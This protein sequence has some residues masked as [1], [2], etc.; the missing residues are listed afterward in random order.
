MIKLVF[1][2]PWDTFTTYTSVP[3][4]LKDLKDKGIEAQGLDL[5]LQI[6]KRLL[7]K[8]RLE[9]AYEHFMQLDISL[10]PPENVSTYNHIKRNADFIIDNIEATKDRLLQKDYHLHSTPRIDWEIISIATQLISFRFYPC[11]WYRNSYWIHGLKKKRPQTFTEMFSH[12]D[13]AESDFFGWA[14]E[15]EE[16]LPLLISDSVLVGISICTLS[17]LLPSMILCKT[18]KKYNKNTHIVLGGA[19][20]RYIRDPIMQ[21]P[22]VFDYADFIVFGRGEDT[23][24]HLYKQLATVGH[25]QDI[26]GVTYCGNNCVISNKEADKLLYN[27]FAP[28]DYTAMNIHEYLCDELEISYSSSYGCYWGKCAFCSETNVNNDFP[29]LV[30]SADIVCQELMQIYNET[31]IEVIEM[32]DNAI[33]VQKALKIAEFV[34]KNK[35]PLK[36]TMLARAEKNFG[37]DELEYLYKGGLRFVSWGIE[38]FNP[39]MQDY[40]H[41]GIDLEYA[42]EILKYSHEI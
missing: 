11:L 28:P 29:Y 32:M 39:R 5:N 36:W 13:R 26:P 9:E 22:E 33:P 18:L 17:Q 4:L 6:I 41:K 35:L 2:P 34:I 14:Y 27:R 21:T 20:L 19:F 30:K 1:P 40:I 24:A 10:F 23:L 25:G 16:I 37:P 12:I 38:T 7:T 3:V 31:G 8:T 15:T 42:V